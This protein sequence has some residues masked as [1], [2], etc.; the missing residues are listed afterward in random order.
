MSRESQFLDTK[1][2]LEFDETGGYDC[3]TS[4]WIIRRNGIKMVA[5]DLAD[6]GQSP[7]EYDYKSAEAE[8]LARLILKT[9]QKAIS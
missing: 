3:M 4:A 9:V 1:F 7:C 2:T 5:I 8:I 6:F